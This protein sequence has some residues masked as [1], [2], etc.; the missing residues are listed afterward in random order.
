MNIQDGGEKISEG[1]YGCVYHPALNC[2]GTEMKTRKYISKIQVDDYTGNN[3]IYISK[4]IRKIPLYKDFFIPVQSFCKLNK[5]EMSRGMI[6]KCE[7]LKNKEGRDVLLMK[8]DYVNGD[9]LYNYLASIESP[10]RLINEIIHTY[11]HLTQSIS[12]LLKNGIIHYDLKSPNIMYSK[13]KNT[14][15]IIDFG[16]SINVED[17]FDDNRKKL[18]DLFYI[19]APDYYLWCPEI[20]FLC[21]MLN[22]DKKLN[23][24]TIKTICKEVIENNNIYKDIYTS[25][26][27]RKQEDKLISYYVGKFNELNNNS[28]EFMD[29]LLG[30]YDTWDN[31]SLSIMYLKIL[32]LMG[33]KQTNTK[34]KSKNNTKNNFVNLFST[35]L[36]QNLSVEPE[37]RLNVVKLDEYMLLEMLE[38]ENGKNLT[39]KYIDGFM[40]FLNN[41]KDNHN[42][43]QRSLLLEEDEI[44]TLSKSIERTK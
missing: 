37:K 24:D 39:D 31:Y 20:H 36:I 26:Q 6:Q 32:L 40:T 34:N 22:V 28:D 12:L 7:P 30:T 4:L 9:T 1:G 2:D 41:I 44:I 11:N 19:Y 3:E 10:K 5:T 15:Y 8:M 42:N 16:L 27:I 35:L 29:F 43:I 33:D 21:Y 38:Y 23:V 18:S 25:L 14:P 13:P 17:I